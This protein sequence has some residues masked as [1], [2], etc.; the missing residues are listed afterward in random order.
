MLIPYKELI[1][2][3]N[4]LPKGV[5]H[6]GANVGQ[7]APDYYS[8]GVNK[9]VW[10]EADPGLIMNLIGNLQPYSNHLIF[11]DCLTDT[12][13]EEVTFHIANNQ[14]QSSSILALG[15]HIQAHPEVHYVQD[16]TLKTKRLDTLFQ[17]NLLNIDDYPFVNIDIQGAE[18]LC[19]KGFG[20]LLNKVKWLYIEV[21]DLS[22][23]QNCAL[24]PELKEYL[25]TFGFVVREKVMSGNHG[26]GD[27]FMI[28]ENI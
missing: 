1:Q 6:I 2:K 22:L 23:Y 13:D 14:G 3:Y 28:N 4:I 11:N 21:N 18:L 10:V 12:D 5:I 9:T 16:I 19:L 25:A 8:N 15:T 27:S 26:W 24:Y 17:N 7:E 20:E